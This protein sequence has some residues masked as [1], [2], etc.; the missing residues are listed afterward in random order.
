MLGTALAALLIPMAILT[1]TLG[2]IFSKVGAVVAGITAAIAGIVALISK[3]EAIKS[4]LTS[5]K[6]LTASLLL[7]QPSDER[8]IDG[9]IEVFSNDGTGIKDAIISEGYMGRN[10]ASIF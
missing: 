6:D 7:Y 8:R 5:F 2:V 4:K 3:W 1:A 10:L 9:K